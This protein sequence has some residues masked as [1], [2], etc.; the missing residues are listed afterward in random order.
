MSMG[1]PAG[2]PSTI[3]T[4]ARPC[5]SPAVVK[6]NITGGLRLLCYSLVDIIQYFVLC[7]LY[8]DFLIADSVQLS[9]QR[10]IP[11]QSTKHK[12]QSTKLDQ[13]F[14]KHIPAPQNPRRVKRPLQSGHLAQVL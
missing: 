12:V 8:F 14:I 7:A 9:I 10:S 3:A 5:D 11:H 4:S 1:R 6:R 13:S 2:K